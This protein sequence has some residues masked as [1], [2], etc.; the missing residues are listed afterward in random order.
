MCTHWQSS[1]LELRKRTFVRARSGNWPSSLIA[2]GGGWA[3]LTEVALDKGRPPTL[4]FNSGECL[5][6]SEEAFT[7]QDL[8][9]ALRLLAQARGVGAPELQAAGDDKV[10]AQG[11]Q[12]WFGSAWGW[13]LPDSD[14][15]AIDARGSSGKGPTPIPTSLLDRLFDGRQRSGIPNTLHRWAGARALPARALIG[16]HCFAASVLSSPVSAWPALLLCASCFFSGSRSIWSARQ[17][18][19]CTADAKHLVSG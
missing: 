7:V 9:P 12:S 8:A 15:G 13:Q 16:W 1:S 17:M 19:L 2:S 4:R 14:P 3:A 5:H 6:L 10:E 11:L 18:R